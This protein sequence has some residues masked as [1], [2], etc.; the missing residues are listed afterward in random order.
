MAAGP[1]DRLA[2]LQ[3]YA[4]AAAVAAVLVYAA[5]L[6]ALLMLVAVGA[7]VFIVMLAYLGSERMGLLLL[8]AAFFT[9]PMYKG[10]APSPGSPVTATDLLFV[11]AFGLLV[12]QLL[13]GRVRLPTL[14]FVGVGLVFSTGLIASAFS[15]DPP[16]SLIS[17]AFW[18]MVMVGLPVAFGLLAPSGKLVD[19]LAAA[20]VA[21]QIFS[22]FYGLARGY[23]E[24]GR[25][26]GFSTHPNY[27][28]QAGMLS[29]ALLLYLGYRHRGRAM[30]LI[31]PAAALCGASVVLS[32]SRAATVV[33]AVLVMMVPVVERS[34]VTGF[35]LAALGALGLLLLPVVTGLA[36]EG[37]SIARLGGDTSAQ[38]SNSA[39]SLGLEEGIDRFFT[40]PFRGT[41]LIELYEIHNNFLEVAVA[42]GI[43]GLVGYLMVLYTFARPL[44]SLGEYRRLSYGVW[45]YVGF[46]ATVPSLYDRSI[47]AVV[48]LSVVAMI[49]HERRRLEPAADDAGGPHD[50]SLAVRA[51]AP[52][53]PARLV[54]SLSKR[55]GV[56]T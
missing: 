25:H 27:F 40:H 29:L 22:M 44:F 20:F 11:A 10:L 9:A 23:S 46:G 31:L 48:A 33:V 49:E 2:T 26:A 16:I 43:F 30:L 24:A 39:R 32:G 36:G 3:L 56:H 19:L 47:W 35:L 54:P 4:A 42:I 1:S 41:G 8:V 50:A 45:A 51:P 21:G 6:G 7:A 38:F 14:Y 52:T 37:S 55:S 15:A 13:R 34:A 17:L 28:A 5:T 12:P 18:M 53:A